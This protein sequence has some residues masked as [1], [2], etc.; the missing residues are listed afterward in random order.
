M[1]GDS[2]RMTDSPG[3]NNTSKTKEKTNVKRID[4]G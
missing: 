3:N 4:K 2:K 1:K